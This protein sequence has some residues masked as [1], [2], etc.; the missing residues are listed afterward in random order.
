MRRVPSSLARRFW[1]LDVASFMLLR[2]AFINV[3]H[4]REKDF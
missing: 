3:E 1:R 4:G 2:F